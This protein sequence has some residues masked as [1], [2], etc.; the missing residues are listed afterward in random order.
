MHVG[1]I[2]PFIAWWL[3]YISVSGGTSGRSSVLRL[4]CC[5]AAILY[6]QIDSDV[7]SLS[8]WISVSWIMVDR[9]SPLLSIS[10]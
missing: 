3:A 9:E 8:D 4:T 1:S 5:T 10:F 6:S 7:D 2:Y